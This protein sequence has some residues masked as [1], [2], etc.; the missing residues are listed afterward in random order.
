[1]LVELVSNLLSRNIQ[2][3]LQGIVIQIHN[4]IFDVGYK[5]P[6]PVLSTYR[7]TWKLFSKEVHVRL[8]IKN[9]AAFNHR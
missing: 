8:I 2:F 5:L 1:M 4:V 3:I 7:V 9:R 6:I